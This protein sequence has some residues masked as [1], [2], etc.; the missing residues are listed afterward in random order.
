[1][2]NDRSSSALRTIAKGAGIAAA[3]GLAAAA[4]WTAY[5]ALFINHRRELPPAIDAKRYTTATPLAGRMCFYA[6]ESAAGTPLVLVHSINAAAS[7]YE[8][9]P[10][11]E[12]Y[13]GKRPVFA[14]DLPGFGFSE[15]ADRGYTSDVFVQALL[16]FVDG[17]LGSEEPVDIVALSLSC[18][19][20]A[21]AAVEQPEAFRSLVMIAPTG[22]GSDTPSDSEELYRALTFPVWAQAF[23]DLLVSPPSI[24]YF[25]QKAFAGP[26]DPGLKEY[27]YLTAHRPGARNVP[28]YFIAGK[29][30]SPDICSY[31]SAVRQPVLA[32]CDQSDYG[33][34]GLL[35]AFA[36]DHGWTVHCIPGTRAMPHFERRDVTFAAMDNFFARQGNV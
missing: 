32:F 13:R 29:L 25:L 23:Y 18:E 1:M 20:A 15:R 24:Q 5:S 3:T 12:H 11:F 4:G 6:E 2:D 33:P 34:S 10:V 22:F 36:E 9:R 7:S 16:D 30:F 27:S 26:V 28:A 31:Y 14:L 8:M 19:F 35:P 17:E 21:I